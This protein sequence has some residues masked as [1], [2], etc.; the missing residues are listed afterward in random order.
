MPLDAASQQM[1]EAMRATN[2]PPLHKIP[3]ADARKRALHNLLAL[4][5]GPTMSHE[6]DLLIDAATTVVVRVFKPAP[7]T[8]GVV[9]VF[10]GGGWVLGNVNAVTPMSRHLAQLA[11][12][13]VVAVGYR[14]APE[15][16]YPAAVDDAVRAVDWAAAHS[17]SLTG[18]PGAP[19]MVLGESAGGNLA[20]AAALCRTDVVAAQVLCCPVTD[21]MMDYPSYQDPA[22]QLTR[23]SEALAS[24]WSE[25]LPDAARRSEPHAS[26]LRAASLAGAPRAMVVLA[27]YDILRDE[28]QA[29]ADGL[30]AAGVPVTARVIDGQ[31]H[32]FLANV[33][34]LPAALSTL[35]DVARF[36]KTPECR[37]SGDP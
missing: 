14:K 10:H 3:L 23:T 6:E 36:L 32:G 8:R 17:D 7:T 28:G 20:A 9:L 31:M 4:G 25:Y 21:H 24:F 12:M 18:C 5:E 37:P 30:A 19:V 33:N 1:L 26:P 22:N 11:E 29:Y 15:H 16:R 34:L 35:E 2:A 27:E 13:T